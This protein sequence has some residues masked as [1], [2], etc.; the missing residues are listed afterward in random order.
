MKEQQVFANIRLQADILDIYFKKIVESAGVVSM[1]A[2]KSF[3]SFKSIV[4]SNL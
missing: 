1:K 2:K 4:E 3:D